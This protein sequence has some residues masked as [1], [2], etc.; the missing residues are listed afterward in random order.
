[1]KKSKY[2]LTIIAASLAMMFSQPLQAQLQVPANYKRS[3]ANETVT[4]KTGPGR[5]THVTVGVAGT[6]SA[7]IFYD[8]TAAS[9]TVIANISTLAAETFTLNVAF[10]TG[11]TY[12]TSGGAAADISISW[13]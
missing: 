10:T 12:V 5:L 8:N 2:A 11:L 7:V 6:T 3:A 4:L 1:M 13:Q 9:G